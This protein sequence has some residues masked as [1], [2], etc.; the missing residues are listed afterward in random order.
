MRNEPTERNKEKGDRQDGDQDLHLFRNSLVAGTG[1]SFGSYSFSL[2]M[3]QDVLLSLSPIAYLLFCICIIVASSLLLAFRY[4]RVYLDRSG[5]VNRRVW[6][7]I[8]MGL[9]QFFTYDI[10]FIYAGSRNRFI[11]PVLIGT[12]LVGHVFFRKWL[13]Y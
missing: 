2:A 10:I 4:R 8:L 12:D 7:H 6:Y 13:S 11:L 9:I 1:L 3:F 5:E